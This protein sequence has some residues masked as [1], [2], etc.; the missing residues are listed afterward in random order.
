MNLGTS[1]TCAKKTQCS[2]SSFHFH[3]IVVSPLL[4][5]SFP[6]RCAK[7]HHFSLIVVTPRGLN[8]ANVDL[9]LLHYA[10]MCFVFLYILCLGRGIVYTAEWKAEAGDGT[11][12]G[13]CARTTS[14]GFAGIQTAR[15]SISSPDPWRRKIRPEPMTR[16]LHRPDDRKAVIYFD[17][18]F[19]F[20]IIF[21]SFI[22][23]N[24]SSTYIYF[25]FWFKRVWAL[26]VCHVK[27]F[28]L[29]LPLRSLFIYYYSIC[30]RDLEAP[31]YSWLNL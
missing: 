8:R 23:K 10:C 17:Q 12:T 21:F 27:Y 9:N 16:L 30:V 29:L 1:S 6:L 24:N 22:K 11:R 26:R 4:W 18:A 31:R 3:Y 7:F 28:W 5:A 19:I 15:T 25:L 20:L 14:R 2:F 13:R